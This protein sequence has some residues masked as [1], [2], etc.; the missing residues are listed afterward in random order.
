MFINRNILDK[1]YCSCIEN[2]VI[3]TETYYMWQV[4]NESLVFHADHECMRRVTDNQ[5]TR[6]KSYVI[7]SYREYVFFGNN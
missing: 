5:I 7:V 1:N 3:T 6:T 2:I 4:S